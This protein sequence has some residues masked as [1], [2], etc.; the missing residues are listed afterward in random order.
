MSTSSFPLPPLIRIEAGP[1]ELAIREFE[2]DGTPL[3]FIHGS[4]DDHY[5]WSDVVAHVRES[6]GRPCLVY[7]R[8]GHSVSTDEAGPGSVQGDV[9]DALHLIRT[10]LQ[11]PAHVVGHSYGASI[12]IALAERA[13]DHV[14]S[15]ALYEPPVFGL[16]RDL[17]SS[18]STLAEAATAAA[19]AADLIERGEVERGVITFIERVAFGPRSWTDLLDEHARAR[20]LINAHTWLDQSKDP[21]RLSVDVLPLDA[22]A[23]HVTLIGGTAGLP[24]FAQ[25]ADRMH[26]LLPRL[27]R[28]RIEG[29]GHGAPLSHARS[30]AE[31]IVEHAERSTAHRGS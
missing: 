10:R 14:Q 22:L 20:M 21:G 23:P 4:L 26:Q 15:L 8:R 7:D 9:D 11:R 24:H 6:S 31:C 2:G 13:P 17:P 29:A 25:V 30:L 18:A 16:L 5:G 3:L 27:Q 19:E 28:M 12:A 1:V